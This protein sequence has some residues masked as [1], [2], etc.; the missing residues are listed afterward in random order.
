[1]INSRDRHHHDYLVRARTATNP[2]SETPEAGATNALIAIAQQQRTDSAELARL[3]DQQERL[4]DT[5]A[6]T[7]AALERIATA[8]ETTQQTAPA[9]AP[10]HRAARLGT[11]DWLVLT[12]LIGSVALY[13]ATILTS[14]W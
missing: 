7:A 14:T 13:L 12:A 3:A 2:Y 4:A 8:L 10:K 11:L 6:R 1:M 9:E 5:Q